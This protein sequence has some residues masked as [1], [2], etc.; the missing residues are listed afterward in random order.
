MK[1]LEGLQACTM[2]TFLDKIQP[3]LGPDLT[4]YDPYDLW[5]TRLGLWLKKIYYEKG[6][7]T[8]PLVAPFF[9]LDAYA[10][11]LIR[12]FINPQE[13]PIV[14]AFAVMSALNFHELTSD[15]KYLDLACNSAQWLVNNRIEGYH[16]ACWGINFPWMTKTGYYSPTTPFITHTPYCVEALLKFSDVI[17]DKKSLETALSSLGFLENDLSILLDDS[18]KM[19]VSYGPGHD[20]RI[21]I[22]ANSYA[23]MLYA[24]LASRLSGKQDSLIN[25]ANRI[26]NFV[27]S[28]QNGD[29]SWFYYNDKESGNFIDCFHSCF[30]MKNLVKYGELTKTDVAAIVNKGLS[31]LL[32]NFMDDDFYLARRF[33]VSANPSLT[34]FDLYDQAELLNLVIILGRI[35]LAKKLYGSII[36]YFY[37]PSMGA[38]GSQIN[39]FGK[40]NK[41]KYLRWAVMPMVYVLSEYRKVIEEKELPCGPNKDFG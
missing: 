9:I 25:K 32:E 35:D 8:T 22:N 40:L 27:V 15:E 20:S 1:S 3:L 36:K 39:N 13:Y 31:Y 28:G 2:N 29:G 6:R 11:G 24:L 38:F 19:A 26:Y 5:K 16:G 12:A 10:P 34:K 33:S 7:I 14:R 30:V 17:N 37:I 18:N 4:T 23:M 21:V 41:I